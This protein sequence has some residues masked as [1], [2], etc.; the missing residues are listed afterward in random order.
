M[1]EAPDLLESQAL[2]MRTL[3]KADRLDRTVENLPDDET[4]TE[5]QG[6]REGLSRAEQC[7]LLAYSKI[8]LYERLLVSSLPDDPYLEQELLDYFPEVLEQ[9]FRDPIGA[10]TLRREIVATTVT[11]KI[12]NRTHATFVS[13]LVERTGMGSADVARAF[14]IVEKSF[15]LGEIWQSIEALDTVVDTEAQIRMLGMV[16]K[17]VDRA[18]DWVLRNCGQNLD[19]ASQVAYFSDGIGSGRYSTTSSTTG[20]GRCWPTGSRTSRSTASRPTRRPRWRRST[21]WPRAWI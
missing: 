18:S 1:A 7:V 8:N 19:I 5:L 6:H 14:M 16:G 11:N 21:S 2:Y 4:L 15:Q 3:E 9:R 12:V 13:E 20:Q 17:L 10:H